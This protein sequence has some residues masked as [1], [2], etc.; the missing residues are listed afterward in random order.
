MRYE[1]CK[2]SRIKTTGLPRHECAVTGT[3]N[4]G[5]TL[6]NC[7]AIDATTNN[8]LLH[9]PR[10]AARAAIEAPL[11]RSIGRAE[12]RGRAIPK[13]PRRARQ[14]NWRRMASTS[15]LFCSCSR[16]NTAS[17]SSASGSGSKAGA[18]RGLGLG[19]RDAKS[20][21][22]WEKAGSGSDVGGGGDGGSCL[23]SVVVCLLLV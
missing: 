9:K 15:C 21:A 14:P 22:F 11:R 7:P 13:A 3:G 4:S 19:M 5:V 1:G 8:S 6:G 10:R 17:S 18:D 12:R 23:L 20:M 16:M 2:M